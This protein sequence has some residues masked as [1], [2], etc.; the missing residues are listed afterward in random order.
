MRRA[1]AAQIASGKSLQYPQ[2]TVT[3]ATFSSAAWDVPEM[4]YYPIV[5]TASKPATD[6]LDPP[7]VESVSRLQLLF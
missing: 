6:F 7:A 3:S 5:H 1:H 4:S 2:S